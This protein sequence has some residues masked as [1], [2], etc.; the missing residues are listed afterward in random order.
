MNLDAQLIEA[1]LALTAECTG[2]IGP[3]VYARFF[4]RCPEGRSL[5]RIID[6]T[7]PPHGCGQML[8]EILSL[9]QD[10]AQNKPYV[11]SYMADI[12][13]EHAGFGVNRRA[14]YAE[15]LQAIMDVVGR[16]MGDHWNTAYEVAWSRQISGLLTLV[17]PGQPK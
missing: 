10:N 5:F 7:Q 16:A 8:F 12:G 3:A 6:A 17:S 4:E 1:S 15:F 2:D 9:L 14:T 13:A 11:R